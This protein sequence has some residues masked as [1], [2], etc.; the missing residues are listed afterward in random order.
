MLWAGPSGFASLPPLAAGAEASYNHPITQTIVTLARKQV[1]LLM[2]EDLHELV[3]ARAD[4][5]GVS[6]T[7]YVLSVLET[8]LNA[9]PKGRTTLSSLALRVRA[10]EVHLGLDS[11]QPGFLRAQAAA[12]ASPLVLDPGEL[13][14]E[15]RR[16]SDRA[17]DRPANAEAPA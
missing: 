16:G 9:D 2:P 15:R 6:L 17:A 13:K 10:I 5:A 14:Q 4:E 11:R 3:R 1:H 12:E 7:A 8:D